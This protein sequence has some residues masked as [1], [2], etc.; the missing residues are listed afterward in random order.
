[1][2][3]TRIP[4]ISTSLGF[5]DQDI[6]H[7][8]NVLKMRN[9]KNKVGCAMKVFVNTNDPSQF[10]MYPKAGVDIVGV[11]WKSAAFLTHA[12]EEMVSKKQ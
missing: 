6:D 7:G 12:Y 3:S 5:F 11:H 8:D 10:A 9:I 1:M 4:L 2:S